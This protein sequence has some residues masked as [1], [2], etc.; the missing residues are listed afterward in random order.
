M[1]DEFRREIRTNPL[2]GR[3]VIYIMGFSG[4]LF[5]ALTTSEGDKIAFF[6]NGDISI[7]VNSPK[8]HLF[9]L[10]EA[11]E[12]GGDGVVYDRK[13][14]FGADERFKVNGFS[15]AGLEL[16][17]HAFQERSNKLRTKARKNYEL[18]Q[19][20][21]YFAY[22]VF[23]NKLG[24]VL[25]ASKAIPQT[26]MD[27]LVMSYRHEREKKRPRHGDLKRD[28]ALNLRE[29]RLSESRYVTSNKHYI[30]FAPFGGED[31]HTVNIFPHA[32]IGRLTE[33]TETQ[34]TSLGFIVYDCMQRIIKDARMQERFF[35]VV[36]VAL[37]SAPVLNGSNNSD[38]MPHLYAPFD[39]HVEISPGKI[40]PYGA[41]FEIPFS[42]W[43]VIP[44][45]PKDVAERLRQA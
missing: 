36:Y 21:P 42:G 30:A 7:I 27:E 10:E 26:I 41:P 39:L 12:V 16:L 24:G 6:S 25:L 5:D 2:T 1:A 35:D 31:Q 32:D 14:A 3:D 33:L 34:T 22:N 23:D 44:D 38:L 17:I 29:R 18:R 8:I 43:K 19:F 28:E 13:P 20:Y 11:T 40:P 45:R 37:H 9:L 4:N 15:P